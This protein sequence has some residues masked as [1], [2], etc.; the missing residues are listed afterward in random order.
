M[1]IRRRLPGTEK[2][3]SEIIPDGDVRVKLMGTVIDFGPNS[4]ILDDGTGKVEIM[5]NEPIHAR[6][7]ELVNVIT[8]IVPL[9]DGFECR[10]EAVQPLDGF[11]ID[12]YNKARKL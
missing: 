12:L 2:K 4:I 5:F 9:I 3:I 8:R 11:D 7:G 6:Q 10:G 1:E